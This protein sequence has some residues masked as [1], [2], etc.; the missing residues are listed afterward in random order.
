[1]GIG[2]ILAA[3]MI[4]LILTVIVILR[5]IMFKVNRPYEALK[6]EISSLKQRVNQLENE[7]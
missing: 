7:D 2:L 3:G 4:V 6:E 1:M 5:S